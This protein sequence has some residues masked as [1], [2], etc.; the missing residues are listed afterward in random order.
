[1]ATDGAQAALA[2]ILLA[3][4]PSGCAALKDKTAPCKRPAGLSSYAA[5]PRRECGPM[6][7]INDPALAFAAIGVI[8]GE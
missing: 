3:A 2:F 1:M 4:L 8:D 7:P 5:D 6:H